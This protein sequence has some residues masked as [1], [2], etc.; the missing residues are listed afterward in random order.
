MTADRSRAESS[1]V[2]RAGVVP[3]TCGLLV[4]GPSWFAPSLRAHRPVKPPATSEVGSSAR[5]VIQ[6]RCG[7]S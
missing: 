4:G 5:S 7:I 2:D 1:R 6:R 3:T